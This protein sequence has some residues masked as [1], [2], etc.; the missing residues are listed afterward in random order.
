MK[1]TKVNIDDP[2]FEGANFRG[3][4]YVCKCGYVTKKMST[5]KSHLKR[6][7]PCEE[8]KP[9]EFVCDCYEE[10]NTAVALAKHKKNCIVLKRK[11]I[12]D[13]K[14]IAIANGNNNVIN[15]GNNNTNNIT[16]I[17]NNIVKNIIPE[18][19]S[20]WSYTQK[21]KFIC[22]D[23]IEHNLLMK[24]DDNHDPYITYFK[25]THCNPNRCSLHNLYYPNKSKDIIF[26]YNGTKW[27][28]KSINMITANIMKFESIDLICFI[29]SNFCTNEK[30]QKKI[31]KRIEQIDPINKKSSVSNEDFFKERSLLQSKLKDMLALCAPLIKKTYDLTIAIKNKKFEQIATYTLS[32][33]SD[34]ISSD[35]TSSKSVFNN[36]ISFDTSTSEST[37]ESISSESEPIKKSKNNTLQSKP[38][39]KT[40]YKS[41]YN[42]DTSS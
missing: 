33:S 5:Y 35:S 19:L 25:L 17:T 42:S 40:I 31:K 7:T 22:L 28:P 12:Y 6:Q 23:S 1:T 14:N 30:T 37:S 10:Y 20:V 18:Y 4:P 32:K 13:K 41:K 38:T 8:Q 27:K 3:P 15:N 36:E 16:N 9:S 26:A 29:N 39:K 24:I 34:S 21:N 11:D 2:A